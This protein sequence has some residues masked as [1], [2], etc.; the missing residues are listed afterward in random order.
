MVLGNLLIFL[1]YILFA[2]TTASPFALLVIHGIGQALIDACAFTSVSIVVGSDMLA[3]VTAMC[4]FSYNIGLFIAPV[5]VGQ[6]AD[7][8]SLA[9]GL[10]VFVVLGGISVVA[11][12]L[13][14]LANRR[15]GGA[16]DK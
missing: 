10:T 4:I 3:K 5:L 13:L 8:V 15:A 1:V 16:L 11:S 9:A 7:N 14:V 6:L 2:Y 12:V